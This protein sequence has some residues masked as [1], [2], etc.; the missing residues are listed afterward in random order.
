LRHPHMA[1][2]VLYYLKKLLNLSKF[3]R[4]LYGIDYYRFNDANYRVYN[5]NQ[6]K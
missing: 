6:L 5:Y 3:R 1:N 2:G 4:L